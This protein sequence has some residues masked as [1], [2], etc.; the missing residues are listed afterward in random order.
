M[1]VVEKEG[2]VWD[3]GVRAIEA[4]VPLALLFGIVEGMRVEEG[5]D[6]LAA[7]IF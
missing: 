4:D 5:P 6:E 7:D 1:S 3:V 2:R